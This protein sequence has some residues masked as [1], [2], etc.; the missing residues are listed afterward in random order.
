MQL[1]G[2]LD[3]PFVRRVAI[4]MRYLGVGYDHR[5]LSIFRDFDEFYALNPL[6][7]VPTLV[8]DDGQIL[9]DSTLI[10]DYLEKRVAGRS[11]M[12][13]ESASYQLALQDTGYALVGME[14][15]AQLIYETQQRPRERQHPDWIV[16][17]EQQL[18]GAV[19]LMEASVSAGAGI[20][21]DR[22]S[23]DGVT[24]GDISIA[25]AWRF[26]QHIDRANVVPEDYPALAELSAGAESL[27]E[28]AACPLSG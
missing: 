11:L 9:T 16:R 21:W 27:P 17:I 8:L 19:G 6:V 18:K 7:K 22:L 26:T 28:F 20:H 1:V 3:S 25:V 14:K 23:G 5:E 13:P 12:A 15:V 24:Q 4:T 2:Y 10:I